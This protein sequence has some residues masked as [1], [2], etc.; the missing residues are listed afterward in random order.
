MISERPQADQRQDHGG[1]HAFVESAHD[2]VGFAQPHK[3]SAD[4]RGDDRKT[5]NGERIDHQLG[6]HL[7]AEID[8]CQHHGSHRGHREGFE[9]VG[10]HAGT[11]ADIVAHIVGDGGGIA[12]IVFGNARF[13]LAHHVAAHVGALGEDA[14]AEPREDGDQR[15]AEAQAHQR[16]HDDAVLFSTGQIKPQPPGEKGVITGHRQQAETHHQHAGD[17]AGAERHR[18]AGG[19]AGARGFGGTHIGPD[20]DIHADITGGARQGRTDQ[21]AERDLPAEEEKGQR[22]DHHADHGDGGVLAVEIGARPFL[23]GGG[24]FLHPGIARRQAQHGPDGPQAIEQRE[25]AT[26]Q[27]DF[28]LH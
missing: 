18:Q 27:N 17:G 3:E 20:R 1:D 22:E 14:A 7:A 5:R 15:S 24:D 8:R 21:K 26:G 9:Q 10:R 12:W 19:Q 23:D 25:H 2:V 4:D 6:L 13:H 11:V 16:I 28:Q